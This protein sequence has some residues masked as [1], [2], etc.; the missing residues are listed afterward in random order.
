MHPECITISITA[1]Q[2]PRREKNTQPAEFAWPEKSSDLVSAHFTLVRSKRLGE[3]FLASQREVGANEVV[4]AARNGFC[5]GPFFPG[6]KLPKIAKIQA[7]HRAARDSACATDVRREHGGCAELLESARQIGPS[8]L[9]RLVSSF[10][11]LG[12]SDIWTRK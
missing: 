12:T 8:I 2:T 7:S 4:A 11:E 10:T 1:R 5:E 3:S 9:M 6:F